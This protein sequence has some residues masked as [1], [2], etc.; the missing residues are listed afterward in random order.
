TRGFSVQHP[1]GSLAITLPRGVVTH[2]FA[3]R[4]HD[5][6]AFFGGCSRTSRSN[7]CVIFE[8]RMFFFGNRFRRPKT[9]LYHDPKVVSHAG[10]DR[11]TES[12]PPV[13]SNVC[14]VCSMSNQE[15]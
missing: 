15:V 5:R 1:F 7:F 11:L 12:T 2:R 14:R 13:H 4:P 8:R 3:S 10:A 6:F 9:T